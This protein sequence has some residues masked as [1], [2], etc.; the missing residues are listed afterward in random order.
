MI[1]L[2]FILVTCVDFYDA[3]AIVDVDVDVYRLIQYNLSFVPFES[4][5]AS[6]NHHAGF[7]ILT[8][9]ADLSRTVIVKK[10]FR[11]GSGEAQRRVVAEPNREW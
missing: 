5:L 8:F 2:L 7:L 11:I 6:L 10:D 1:A 4:C 9:S 3:V